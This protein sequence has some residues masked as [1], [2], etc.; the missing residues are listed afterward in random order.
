MEAVREETEARA[1]PQKDLEAAEQL[2]QE[3]DPFGCCGRR[4]ESVRAV[5]E[6]TL[7]RERGREAGRT[8]VQL[9]VQLLQRNAVVVHLELPL[10]ALEVRLLVL[11]AAP[12]VLLGRPIFGVVPEVVLCG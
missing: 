6:Q 5:F 10:Q 3:L 1:D 12:G 7:A 9:C 8:C 11:P 2:L 4:R